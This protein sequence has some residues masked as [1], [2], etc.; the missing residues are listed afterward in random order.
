[1]AQ[2]YTLD[3]AAQKLAISP[4]DFKKKLKTDPAFTALRPF[5]DGPTLRFRAADIDELGRALGGASDPGFAIGPVGADPAESADDL[6]FDLTQAAPAGKIPAAKDD[7][8]LLVTDDTDDIFT[9]LGPAAASDSDVRLD[10]APAGPKPYDP[11]AS[12]PTEEIALDLAGPGSAVIRPSGLSGNKLAPKSGV[13]I[14]PDSGKVPSP[15]AG[16]PAGRVPANPD[17]SSEFELNVDP[18]SDSLEFELSVDSDAEVNLGGGPAGG[19]Q[20]GQSG[21]NLNRPADSGVSLEGKKGPK[22]GPLNRRPDDSDSID[23]FELSLD[24]GGAPA[25][26]GAASRSMGG[27]DSDSEFELTLDDNSGVVDDL[28]TSLQGRGRS[29]PAARGPDILETDFELPAMADDSADGSGA[30]SLSG[31]PI[32]AE[33]DSDD[34]EVS[35]DDVALADPDGEEL[36]VED[37]EVLAADGGSGPR[38]GR[39]ASSLLADDDVDAGPSASGALRDLGRRDDYARPA[40]GPAAVLPPAQWG[41]LPAVVLLLTLP[42]VFVGT[43]SSF[44]VLKGML[45]YHQ[46]NAPSNSLVKGVAGI[47]G[48]KV[49]E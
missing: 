20:A 38:S 24:P 40:A 11:N 5:R 22:T 34:F 13:K 35:T 46:S 39:R 28:A 9:G 29:V 2:F 19:T 16:P 47:L 49:T 27:P 21:I 4:E 48:E 36:V 17:S 37:D 15:V 8:P 26:P 10:I 1:M 32:A 14:A 6:V 23:D 3:E 30:G 7:A 25:R 45:G 18:D 33:A 12:H 31:S 42:F 44:E 41:A 43:L